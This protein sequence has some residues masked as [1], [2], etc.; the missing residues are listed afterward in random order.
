ML[1]WILATFIAFFVKGLCGFANTLVFTSIMSFGTGNAAISPVELLLGYPTNLIL[2]LKN[3]KQL[4]LRIWLPLSLLVLAASIPGALLLKNTDSH[5]IKIVFG[6]AVVLIALEMLFRNAVRV[7]ESS[8]LLLVTGIASGLL[9]G[10]FGI[11]AL[12]A[13]YVGRATKS[14]RSFK[15][16]LSA[17]FLT[18]NTVRVFVYAVLGLITRSTLART[19]VLLP[20]MLLGLFA[21]MKSAEL[22]DSRN[23]RIVQKLVILLLIISGIVLILQS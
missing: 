2:L 3:R 16:N 17:V 5:L 21:G 12:L 14:N 19:A 8:L 9:C 10:L 23:D 20:V 13:A 11:G 22:L 15:A 1:L 6:I 18:E 7:K 4:E